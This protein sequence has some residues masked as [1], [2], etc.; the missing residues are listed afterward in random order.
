MVYS[1]VVI[2]PRHVWW[3]S[4][5]ARPSQLRHRRSKN[6]D[7]LLPRVVRATAGSKWCAATLPLLY[8]GRRALC[9]A[10]LLLLATSY[11]KSSN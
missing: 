6:P 4:E 9:M 7:A 10:R 2:L 1:H 8:C 5:G 11:L 3:R